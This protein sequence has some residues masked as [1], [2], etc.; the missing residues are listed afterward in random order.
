[1][2]LRSGSIDDLPHLADSDLAQTVPDMDEL[3]EDEL[4]ERANSEIV[5]ITTFPD[6][7]LALIARRPAPAP[8]PSGSELVASSDA[9][10]SSGASV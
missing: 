7:P 8:P 5:T 9:G 3:L 4:L 2:P 1:M 6:R 10:I